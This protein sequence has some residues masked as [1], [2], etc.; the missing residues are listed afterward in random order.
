MACKTF[1]SD[2]TTCSEPSA[3]QTARNTDKDSTTKKHE[4]K[5]NL[6]NDAKMLLMT[7]LC[8]RNGSWV[9]FF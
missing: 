2:G 1:Y 5:Q 8:G 9:V 7:P 3:C 4:T 6:D